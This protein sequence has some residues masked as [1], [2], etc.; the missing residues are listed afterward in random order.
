[1]RLGPFRPDPRKARSTCS[2]R[3]KGSE[4]PPPSAGGC[5]KRRGWVSPRAWPPQRWFPARRLTGPAQY[6]V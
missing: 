6:S 2:R 3:S 1:M 4:T 5:S